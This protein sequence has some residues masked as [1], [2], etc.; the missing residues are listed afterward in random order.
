MEPKVQR[1]C[2]S[3][4]KRR[5]FN[6]ICSTSRQVDQNNALIINYIQGTFNKGN[7]IK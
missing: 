3:F 4:V 6:R 1:K 7:N 2:E 5:I